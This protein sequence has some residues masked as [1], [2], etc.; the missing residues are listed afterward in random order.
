MCELLEKIVQKERAEGNAE[1]HA[2]VAENMLRAG[3]FTVESIAQL[4]SLT[5]E[6]VLRIKEKIS[7]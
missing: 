3:N 4:C 7:A 1:G 6:Q 5:V 2:D